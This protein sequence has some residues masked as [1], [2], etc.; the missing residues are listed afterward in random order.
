[1]AAVNDYRPFGAPLEGDGG[2][3]YGFTGDW[4]WVQQAGTEAMARLDQQLAVLAGGELPEAEPIEAQVASLPLLIGADGVMAPFR[5]DGGQPKGRTVW[6][7]VKVGILARLGQRVT[8]AGQVVAHLRRR[9]L[10]AVL[11]DIDTLQPRLW[12]ESVRQG[13]LIAPTVVW[14]CDGGRGFWRL[15]RDQFE[16]HAQG[17]LDF[18][19]AAQYL[20]KGA[21]S[22]LDGRTQRA[23]LW[24]AQTRR[25]LRQGQTDQVLLDIKAALMLEGLPDSARKTLQNLYD[26]LDTHRDHIDYARFKELGLPIGSGMVESAC[27]WL[28]QQRFKGVGMRWSEAG[29]NHLLHLRLAW[30][31]GRFNDLFAGAASPNS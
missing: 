1:V 16:A 29:F 7:E 8:K 30:V 31:N 17:V 21:K 18:Y 28:I 10:V 24:F 27:K 9:R 11:G 14:L 19:H 15:F 25:K 23:R 4:N 5:P 2:E 6:R 3:P 26:Y 12:L 22:W 13:I 20:W